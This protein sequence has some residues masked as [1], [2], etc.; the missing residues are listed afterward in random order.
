MIYLE[1][2]TDDE[3]DKIR[4]EVGTTYLNIKCRKFSKVLNTYYNK[5]LEEVGDKFEEELKPFMYATFSAL[6]TLDT[7]FYYSRKNIFYTNFN[8]E[9]PKFKPISWRKIKDLVIK[10]EELGYVESYSGYNDRLNNDSMSSCIKF[11]DKYINLFDKDLLSRFTPSEY[12]SSVVVMTEKDSRGERQ[13]KKNIQGISARRKD[14]DKINT[15]LAKQQFEFI[16]SEKL[17]SLQQK[18]IESLDNSGR[19]YFGELQCIKSD[20]RRFY[21]INKSSVTERDY[22]SNH[23]LIVAE[24]TKANLDEDFL[25]YDLD[26]SDLIQSEDPTK[27]RK[28]LKSVC[29]FLLNSGTPE[30]SFKKLWKESRELIKKSIEKED[31][32]RVEKNIFYK[33]SGLENSKELVKRVEQHNIYAKDY[34]RIKGG[35]WG[36]LQFL[37]ASILLECMLSLVDKNIPFLPYHDSVLVREQDGEVLVEEMRNAWEKVLGDNKYCKIKR[38]F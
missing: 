7:G 4:I 17:V 15:F 38:E 1:D 18:F 22:V 29:M 6:N 20:K 21:K 10:L 24:I 36:E 27:I 9:N 11:T 2:L 3:R 23:M 16:I 19:F 25:P 14:V 33:V 5:I 12:E 30:A 32:K 8:K 35:S 37:D 26:V 34:F 13:V 31:W 28:I